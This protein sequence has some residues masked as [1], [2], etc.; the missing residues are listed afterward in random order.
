MDAFGF[1]A[2]GR[3]RDCNFLASFPPEMVDV[4]ACVGGGGRSPTPPVR[5]PAATAPQSVALCEGRGCSS[6]CR[7][8][9]RAGRRSIGPSMLS[10][11]AFVARRSRGVGARQQRRPRCPAA[12][13]AIERT[14]RY[15]VVCLAGRAN[16]RP[17]QSDPRIRGSARAGA[18]K[19]SGMSGD[20][21]MVSLSEPLLDCVAAA[22][23]LKVRVSWCGM[24]RGLGI[25]RAC[26][27]GGV[28]ALPAR[29]SK[30]GS[31][32]RPRARRRRR[33]AAGARGRQARR[34]PA[35][36]AVRRRRCWRAWRRLRRGG[37]VGVMGS[38]PGRGRPR[39][40]AVGWIVRRAGRRG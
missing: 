23:L 13:R 2:V 29:C 5:V 31:R 1:W 11:T 16:E 32:C 15:S 17:A 7:W 37:E 26:G 34:A 28:C 35:S 4:I 33:L 6:G 12:M 30:T 38:D 8:V 39:G 21:E 3:R 24:R 25:C 20:G 19:E 27:S 40:M 22:A 10:L 9:G 14:R 18:R 36:G